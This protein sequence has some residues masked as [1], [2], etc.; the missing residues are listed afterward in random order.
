M[1][2]LSNRLLPGSGWH[3]SLIM[4]SIGYDRVNLEDWSWPKLVVE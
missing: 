4:Y 1:Y 3:R 2:I